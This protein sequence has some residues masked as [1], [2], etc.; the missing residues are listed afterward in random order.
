MSDFI[1]KINNKKKQTFIILAAGV[2]KTR[3]Q[4]GCKSMIEINKDEKLIDVQI[5]IIKKF[6]ITADIVLATGFQS[7][8]L[9]S[10]VFKKHSEVRVV[11]NK[12]Y[13]ETTPLESLR[14]SLNCSLPQDTF[15]IYGDRIFNNKTISFSDMS[16]P[17]IVAC[18]KNRNKNSAGLVYQNNK[19]KRITYGAKRGWGQIFYIPES[20][21]ETFR[22][23]VNNCKKKYYN[24]FDIINEFSKTTEFYVHDNKEIKIR[25]IN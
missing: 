5:N 22:N 2:N 21:F 6:N 16:K 3:G 18:D 14:L 12:N 1:H 10:H 24:I 7:N 25:E 15:I 4:S 13:K 20:L 9:I 19:L 17:N 11:E 8:T 23:I